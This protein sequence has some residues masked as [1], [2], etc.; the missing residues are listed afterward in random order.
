MFEAL[1][2][3][4]APQGLSVFD[5]HPIQ[6]RAY[7]ETLWDAWRVAAEFVPVQTPGQLLDERESSDPTDAGHRRIA[8][9]RPAV[10]HRVARQG[11]ARGARH[12]V[13][14][15]GSSQGRRV[16]QRG[17]EHRGEHVSG[18]AAL[19]AAA[20]VAPPDVRVSRREHARVRHRRG[21][22]TRA[23]VR[24]EARTHYECGNAPVGGATEDPRPAGY[25]L[26]RDALE[27][28]AARPR[29]RCAATCTTASS[30][31]T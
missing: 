21:R 14:H 7:L 24:R 31:S 12:R 28:A 27:L 23:L 3:E 22:P 18:V 5:F 25:R 30:P 8:R 13:Q 9:H 10:R 2:K 26:H 29:K 6:L 15:G 19:T 11:A 17:R 1:A 4:L 20:P 16:P